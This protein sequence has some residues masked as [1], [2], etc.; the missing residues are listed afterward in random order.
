MVKQYPVNQQNRLGLLQTYSLPQGKTLNL[1]ILD[2]SVKLV[3]YTL[4]T[5]FKS[6]WSPLYGGSCCSQ[7]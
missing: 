3:H 1:V 4:M 6:E 7:G 5:M 2:F